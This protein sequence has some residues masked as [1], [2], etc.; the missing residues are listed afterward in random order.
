[1]QTLIRK[2]EPT[3]T[4]DD[5]LNGKILLNDLLEHKD[6]YSNFCTYDNIDKLIEIGFRN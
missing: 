1:M 4:E 3:A 5:N 2:L 6:F